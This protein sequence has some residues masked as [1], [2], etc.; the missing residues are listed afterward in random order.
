MLDFLQGVLSI[1]TVFVRLKELASGLRMDFSEPMMQFVSTSTFLTSFQMET[2][3]I[4]DIRSSTECYFKELCSNAE[5]LKRLVG[6][7]V[8][9]LVMACTDFFISHLNIAGVLLVTVSV[10]LVSLSEMSLWY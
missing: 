6:I 3:V 2:Q 7:E 10:L 1:P 8:T 5:N 9:D 4:W